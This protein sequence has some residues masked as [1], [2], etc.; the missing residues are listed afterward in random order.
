MQSTRIGPVAACPP[1]PNTANPAPAARTEIGNSRLRTP[2]NLAGTPD[3]VW[4]DSRDLSISG[5]F[6][7]FGLSVNI[8]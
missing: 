3:S 5:A 7:R 1:H 6:N 2:T 4:T 8:S